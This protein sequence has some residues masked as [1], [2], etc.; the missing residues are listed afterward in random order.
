VDIITTE[1]YV[2]HPLEEVLNLEECTTLVEHKELAP[3]EQIQPVNYDAKDNEINGKLEDIYSTAM[4]QVVTIADE[5]DRVEGK[6]KARIGEVSATMLN[7]ALSAVREQAQIKQHKDKNTSSAGTGGP[8]TIN[9]L[10]VTADR[11]EIL[12]LLMKQRTNT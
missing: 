7:V 3:I 12:Q 11:N 4:G 10:N 8:T 2:S 1:K 6:Y 5:M 9:N